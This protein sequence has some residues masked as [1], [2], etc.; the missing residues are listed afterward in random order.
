MIYI[1]ISHILN[2]KG[3]LTGIERVEHHIVKYYF[4]KEVIF[5]YWQ[6][7]SFNLAAKSLI[8]SKIIDRPHF[9][10]IKKSKLRDLGTRL[11]RLQKAK[12]TSKDILLVPAG[13]WDNQEY[14]N[15]LQSVNA[16]LIHVVYDMIPIVCP[17]YVVDYLPPIFTNYMFKVLPK[18]QRVLSISEATAED[19]KKVFQKNNLKINDIRVFRLGDDLTD[20]NKNFKK[21]YLDNFCLCVGTVE[22]RKNHM[23]LYY[24]YKK[25][26]SE[27]INLPKLIIV[28]KKGWL[29]NDFMY[30]INNDPDIRNKIIHLDN[31]TDGELNWLYKHCLFTVFPSFYEGWGLPIAE[32][33]FHNKV[34]L[35]SNTSSMLEIGDDNA[36]YFSPNST[37]EL[38]NLM[39]KFLN[40]AK[41]QGREKTIQYQT[42]SWKSSIKQFN[43][44]I[45]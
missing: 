23:L 26:I 39:K 35:S 43:E 36:D 1:D 45:E 25:A 18:C 44:Y 3:N 34:T 27:K 40:P 32:S 24:V 17:Q 42:T 15:T 10:N 4:N 38:F 7:N 6:N 9:L 29:T 11:I 28:G 20:K 37:D 31:V 8:K 13:L 16:K 14:I 12:L 5:I 30:L 21:L 33:L 19:L 22:V 41:R 2:W